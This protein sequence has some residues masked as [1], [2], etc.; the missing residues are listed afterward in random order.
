MRLPTKGLSERKALLGAEMRLATRFPQ[1]G[2]W[3]SIRYGGINT[4]YKNQCLL[5]SRNSKLLKLL[6]E[7]SEAAV[8]AAGLW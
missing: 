1:A 2:D 6:I 5:S 7:N 3:L 8:T 4:A